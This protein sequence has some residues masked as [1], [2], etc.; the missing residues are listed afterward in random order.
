MTRPPQAFSSGVLQDDIEYGPHR[1]IV[2]HQRDGKVHTLEQVAQPVAVQDRIH[3]VD[4][5]VHERHVQADVHTASHHL[6]GHILECLLHHRRVHGLLRHRERRDLLE[7]GPGQGLP[8]SCCVIDAELVLPESAEELVGRM[9]AVR[10]ADLEEQL[11]R[12]LPLVHRRAE[13]LGS[14]VHVPEQDPRVGL[15]GHVADLDENRDRLVACCR[16]VGEAVVEDVVLG[17]RTVSHGLVPS[18]S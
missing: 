11:Q 2:E 3:T 16:C 5:H 18:V 14:V 8:W 12:L 6:L 9:L 15:A 4:A 13:V 7:V 1:R 10:I 17:N